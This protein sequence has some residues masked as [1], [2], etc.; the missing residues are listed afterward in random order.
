MIIVKIPIKKYSSIHIIQDL[1]YS[2]DHTH[3]RLTKNIITGKGGVRGTVGSLSS[4]YW[5]RSKTII[6]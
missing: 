6:Y 3:D 1:N 2:L 4:P 5:G